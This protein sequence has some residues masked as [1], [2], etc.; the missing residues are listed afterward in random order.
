MAFYST[1]IISL[2]GLKLDR[3]NYRMVSEATVQPLTPIE[4]ELLGILMI[5]APRAVS[6]EILIGE[7]WATEYTED[8]RLLGAHIGSLRRKLI[9]N[10]VWRI[11]T[12]RA[13]GY[14]LARR[15]PI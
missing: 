9:T 5:N 13:L 2:D 8:S 4:A 1:T 7:V 15:T 6:R 3:A 10:R 12:V 14:R 11:E